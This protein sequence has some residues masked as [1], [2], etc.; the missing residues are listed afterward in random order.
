MHMEDQQ[1]GCGGTT[2]EE[3]QEIEM[4]DND[5]GNRDEAPDGI[6]GASSSSDS[7]SLLVQVSFLGED[8]SITNGHGCIY[9]R[10]E[11]QEG[12]GNFDRN[13]RLVLVE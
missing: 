1:P 9:L 11:A 10:F 13:S 6:N 4:E 8:Q 7:N 12:H 3:E 5:E 2:T